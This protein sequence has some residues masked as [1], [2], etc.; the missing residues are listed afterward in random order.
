MSASDVAGSANPTIA[1]I[2]AKLE[3][4]P[5]TGLNPD[6]AQLRTTSSTREEAL[7]LIRF[8]C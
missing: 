6:Q 8:C 7:Q 4:D 1:E 5:K 3:T 2:L